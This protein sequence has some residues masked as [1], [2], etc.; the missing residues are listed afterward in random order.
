MMVCDRF[1]YSGLMLAARITLPH[2]SVSSAMSMSEAGIQRTALLNQIYKVRG[3]ASGPCMRKRGHRT[4]IRVH[5]NRRSCIHAGLR[6]HLTD[7]E[8]SKVRGAPR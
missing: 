1:A 4:G 3:L 8:N 5:V 2:F 6:H 7:V